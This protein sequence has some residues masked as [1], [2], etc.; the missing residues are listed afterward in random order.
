MVK[1][2]EGLY[3]VAD[4]VRVQVELRSRSYCTCADELSCLM[5]RSF[6]NELYG[7]GGACKNAELKVLRAACTVIDDKMRRSLQ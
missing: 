6:E 1:E 3:V 7:T 4:A 2:N 5:L